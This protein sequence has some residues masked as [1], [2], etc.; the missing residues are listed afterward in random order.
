MTGVAEVALRAATPAD[1]EAIAELHATS[2]QDAYRG[3]LPDQHLTGP[4]LEE[5]RRH[6][7]Q[8]MRRVGPDDVVLVAERAGRLIG[9]VAVWQCAEAGYDAMIANL[10]VRPG[11]R[12]RALG[13]RL[14]GAAAERL[15]ACGHRSACLWVY[16]ANQAAVR[17]YERLGGRVE[18]HG[19]EEISG[20]QIPQ[21]RFV[22]RDL[23]A[24][25]ATCREQA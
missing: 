23:E 12:G 10:H 19:F 8:A 24:L 16:A 5:G 15:T 13:R 1:A 3:I 2:W 7:R 9:F 21:T 11:L 22:W 14:L 6:W 20:A 18:E 4:I 25:A 17:F